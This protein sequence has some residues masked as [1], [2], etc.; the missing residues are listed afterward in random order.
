M[1][2]YRSGADGKK[3]GGDSGCDLCRCVWE[4]ACGSC[5]GGDSC[6]SEDDTIES[7]GGGWQAEF[8][9]KLFRILGIF[10][11]FLSFQLSFLHQLVEVGIEL[12]HA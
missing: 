3:V 2:S 12:D 6:R 8:F 1:E 4:T 9:P 10:D 5:F 7:L 11:C